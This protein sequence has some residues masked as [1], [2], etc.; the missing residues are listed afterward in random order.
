MLVP[1]ML[2]LGPAGASIA[3]CTC[4]HGAE[5]TCPMH[6]PTAA[7]PTMCVIRSVTTSPTATL[8][9]LFGLVGLVSDLPAAAVPMPTVSAVRLEHASTTDRPSPPDLPPP[10]A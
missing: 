9:A 4:A 5:A 10:R 3:Q 8:S 7:N 1:A 6:H 2:A